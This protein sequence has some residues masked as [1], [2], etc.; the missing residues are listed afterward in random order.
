M[1]EAWP[2]VLCTLF[3]LSH[4]RRTFISTMKVIEFIPPPPF[5]TPSHRV[6]A[7]ADRHR[8]GD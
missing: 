8:F 1:N 7:A 2:F 3:Q 5:N 6:E 4:E